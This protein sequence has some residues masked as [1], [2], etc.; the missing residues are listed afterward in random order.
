VPAPAL[1]AV[2]HSTTDTTCDNQ[3][4]VAPPPVAEHLNA[5]CL[6]PAEGWHEPLGVAEAVEAPRSPGP[7]PF[8][9]AGPPRDAACEGAVAAQAACADHNAAPDVSN[10][11]GSLCLGTE[12]GR[13]LSFAPG[14]AAAAQAQQYQ[15]GNGSSVPAEMSQRCDASTS[16]GWGQHIAPSA[17]AAPQPTWDCI[18][19]RAACTGSI[20]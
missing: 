17:C 8:P 5:Q 7:P 1:P 18:V 4:A 9:A 15:F 3:P 6:A 20:Y 16:F 13:A 14:S 10:R 2:H 19:V 12:D 11:R